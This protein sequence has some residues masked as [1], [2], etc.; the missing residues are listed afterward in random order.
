[1]TMKVINLFLRFRIKNPKVISIFNSEMDPL[2]L[3]SSSY[4]LKLKNKVKIR[5]YEYTSP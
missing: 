3:M 4:I 5:N 1:M 2:H